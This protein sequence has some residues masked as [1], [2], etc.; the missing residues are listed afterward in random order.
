MSATVALPPPPT[1]GAP[2]CH[3]GV[4]CFCHGGRPII[5]H[6]SLNNSVNDTNDCNNIYVMFN[7]YFSIHFFNLY[8]FILFTSTIVPGINYFVVVTHPLHRL[9]VRKSFIEKFMH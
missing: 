5:Q 3:L 9:Q 8:A 4:G 2:P 6:I 1:T 7:A